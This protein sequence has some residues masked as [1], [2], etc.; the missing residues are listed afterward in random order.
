MKILFCLLSCLVSA[1]A[2]DLLPIFY[3][4]TGRTIIDKLNTNRINT[5]NLFTMAFSNAAGIWVDPSGSDTTGR[6]GR[7]DKQFA[8]PFAAKAAAQ[9]G[10]TITV[11]AGLYESR[12]TNLFF[13]GAWRFLNPTLRFVDVP[14]NSGGWGLFDDRFS[15]AVTC[16]ISGTLSMEYHSGTNIAVNPVDCT[17]SYNTNALGPIVVTNRNTYVR[18]DADTRLGLC[19][20]TPTPFALTILQCVSNSYF[21]R[22]EIYNLNPSNTAVITTNCPADPGTLYVMGTGCAG[23]HWGEGDVVIEANIRGMTLQAVW[24]DN[25]TTNGGQMWI[26]GK[27]CDG[28]WYLVGRTN[29]WKI[30][31]DF[32]EYMSTAST[33]GGC[34][35]AWNSGS[36]YFVGKKISAANGMPIVMEVPDS[37][38]RDTNLIV[39]VDFQKVSG[40]NGWARIK[41]GALRGRIGHFE[42]NGLNVQGT[43][44]LIVTNSGALV[45]LSGENMYADRVAIEHGGGRTDLRGFTIWSTNRDPVLVLATNLHLNSV[46]LVVGT[47]ATNAARAPSAQQVKLYGNCFATS[48]FHANVTANVGT[49]NVDADTD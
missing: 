35:D 28:T 7:Q 25:L 34:I 42:Q 10:D 49:L 24:G 30:W 32:D 31:A 21:K 2:A 37:T 19:G 12:V 46:A 4:D 8:T 39:W 15:G 13:N 38:Q 26:S 20:Q 5:T 3:T 29:T 22:F 43:S 16:S 9:P 18:W 47:G 23:V 6:R 1:G 14:T 36:H 44:G 27:I 17:F 48:N 45:S 41:H 40:S 33:I 11:N